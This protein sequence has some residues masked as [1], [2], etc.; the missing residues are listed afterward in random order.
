MGVGVKLACCL[1]VST[2]DRQRWI[3]TVPFSKAAVAIPSAQGLPGVPAYRGSP[4]HYTPHRHGGSTR[5]LA[6]KQTRRRSG[7]ATPTICC[8]PLLKAGDPTLPAGEQC[9][10][11]LAEGGILVLD[12]QQR[13]R[14]LRKVVELGQSGRERLFIGGFRGD[15]GAE[16]VDLKAGQHRWYQPSGHPV[17]RHRAR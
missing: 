9:L 1:N 17:Y 2:P 14:H 12:R 7:L 10:Q 16:N 4:R 3:S 5:W 15:A 11:P 8:L 13:V 6:R